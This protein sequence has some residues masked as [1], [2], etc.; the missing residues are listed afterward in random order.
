MIV[1]FYLAGIIGYMQA[2]Q[3]MGQGI[4]MQNSQKRSHNI[5]TTI[6]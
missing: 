4:K 1:V 6:T 3:N 5:N 2:S